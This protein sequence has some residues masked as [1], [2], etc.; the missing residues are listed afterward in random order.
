MYWPSDK[1]K[2]VFQRCSAFKNNVLDDDIL[3]LIVRKDVLGRF[4]AR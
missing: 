1:A 3:A 4:A 2:I